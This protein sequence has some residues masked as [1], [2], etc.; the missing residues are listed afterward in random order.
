MFKE[1]LVSSYFNLEFN[2]D[3]LPSLKDINLI[4]LFFLGLEYLVSK[5]LMDLQKA[6]LQKLKLFTNINLYFYSNFTLQKNHDF[7]NLKN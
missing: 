2:F 3:L 6:K 5:L 7:L 4:N 1:L